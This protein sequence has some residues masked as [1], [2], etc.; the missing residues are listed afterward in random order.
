MERLAE[1]RLRQEDD[2]AYEQ[3]E[4]YEDDE[5]YDDEEYEDEDLDEDPLTEEQRM[6]EGRKMFQTFAARLFEQRVLTAYREKV[7]RERQEQ[8]LQEI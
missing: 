5:E 4:T 6:E 7:A 8:L 3:E 1:R 2:I